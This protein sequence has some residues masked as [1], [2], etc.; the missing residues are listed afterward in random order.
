[1]FASGQVRTVA[2][3]VLCGSG[4]TCGLAL[5]STLGNAAWVAGAILMIAG[6]VVVA[7]PARRRAR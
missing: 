7:L 4:A 5:S 6:F 1:M 2:G 3:A